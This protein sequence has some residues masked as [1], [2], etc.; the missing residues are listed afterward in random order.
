MAIL[1]M[2]SHLTSRENKEKSFIGSATKFLAC[3]NQLYAKDCLLGQ[4]S[5]SF[6][7]QL[8]RIFLTLS[9][10]ILRCF[11]RNIVFEADIINGRC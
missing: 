4:D 6:L 8:L 3:K 11:R 9:L 7:R 2:R 1:L 10:R 5:Q